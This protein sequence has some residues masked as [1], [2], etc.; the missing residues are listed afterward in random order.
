MEELKLKKCEDTKVDSK[1]RKV[2]FMD[3]VG[4]KAV[5]LLGNDG[6]CLEGMSSLFM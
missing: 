4:I 1:N 2:G 5:L 3:Q 6:A